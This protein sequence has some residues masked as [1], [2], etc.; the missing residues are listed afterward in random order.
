MIYFTTDHYISGKPSME[1]RHCIVEDIRNV[2]GISFMKYK[3]LF[4]LFVHNITIY[5]VRISYKNV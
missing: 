1:E 2:H 4:I 3:I 5:V